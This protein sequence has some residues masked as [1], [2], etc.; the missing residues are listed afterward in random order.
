MLTSDGLIE[1]KYQEILEYQN[2]ITNAAIDSL[3]IDGSTTQIACLGTAI[4]TSLLM[5]CC[6]KVFMPSP[7]RKNQ[8]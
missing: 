2:V 5:V 1:L 8:R 7:N 4:I 3:T 6:A